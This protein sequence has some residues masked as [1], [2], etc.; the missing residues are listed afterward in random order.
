MTNVVSVFTKV[1]LQEAMLHISSIQHTDE[2]LEE[3]TSILPVVIC[4]LIKTGL[5]TTYL[6]FEDEFYS[7]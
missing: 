6:I 4:S 3:L 2:A 5:T 1:P 7:V